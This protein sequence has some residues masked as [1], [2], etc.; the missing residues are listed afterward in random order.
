[1]PARGG[2]AVISRWVAS[3]APSTTVLA[4]LEHPAVA[5][6]YGGG[7]H[8]AQRSP[9]VGSARPARR[10]P[11]P[12]RSAPARLGGCAAGAVQQT[13]AH[14]D[15]VDVR[16]DD[17]RVAECLGDHHEFD[18]V[19][20][21]FRRRPRAGWRRECPV[22]RRIRARCRAANP[23]RSWRPFGSCPGRSGSPRN[24]ASPSR[25]SCCSLLRVKSIG[26]LQSECRF[27]ED[28]ALNLV[29]AGV[30]RARA[31]V[32]VPQRRHRLPRFPA[33]VPVRGRVVFGDRAARARWRVAGR[34]GRAAPRF[35]A[36]AR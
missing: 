29:A 32:E 14:H 27:G 17:Q 5:V 31:V 15:G 35:P 22:R 18:R 36:P 19:R 4:P 3:G 10:S 33:D 6:A 16:F 26:V 20:R 11:R 30:D 23:V 2:R 9:D 34:P 13:A 28:V 21:R 12:S 24:L 7:R 1:M 8:V 25:S